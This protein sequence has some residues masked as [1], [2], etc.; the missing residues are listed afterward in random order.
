MQATL[1]L[2]PGSG[3]MQ[4]SLRQYHAQLQ[5]YLEKHDPLLN[6]SDRRQIR[7]AREDLMQQLLITIGA[8]QLRHIFLVCK[9]E[10]QIERQKLHCT[11]WIRRRGERS[12]RQENET[13][14]DENESLQEREERAL[15]ALQVCTQYELLRQTTSQKPKERRKEKKERNR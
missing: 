14:R 13:E 12:R 1:S 9:L 3:M 15:S 5:T 6:L 11:V 4:H 2:R 8:I 7:D 10:V